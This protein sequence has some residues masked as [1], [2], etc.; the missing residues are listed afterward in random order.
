MWHRELKPV[1]CNSLER[2]VR[3]GGVKEER[4]G[5]HVYLWPIHVDVWQKPS[6][7]GK[8]IILQ[9]KIIFLKRLRDCFLF[10]PLNSSVNRSVVSGSLWP[11]ELWPA[12]FLCPWDSPSKNTGVDFHPLLRRIFPTQGWNPGL[13]HCRKILYGLSLQGGSIPWIEG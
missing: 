9:L 11:H 2:G 13:L 6:Q 8:A 5:P 4:E 3:V 10:C 1:L 7:Y 12:R